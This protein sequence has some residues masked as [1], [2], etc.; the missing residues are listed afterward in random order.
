MIRWKNQATIQKV[1]PWI[2]RFVVGWAIGTLLVLL[3]GRLWIRFGSTWETTLGIFAA[4]PATA[5]FLRLQFLKTPQ[6]SDLG[7]SLGLWAVASWVF[8]QPWVSSGIDTFLSS[9]DVETVSHPFWGPFTLVAIAACSVFP[10]IA[11]TGLVLTGDRS[12][13]RGILAGVAFAGVISPMAIGFPGG[14]GLPVWGAAVVCMASGALLLRRPTHESHAPESSQEDQ[15]VIPTESALNWESVLLCFA[16]GGAISIGHFLGHQVIVPNLITEFS[17]FSGLLIG[18]LLPSIPKSGRWMTLAIWASLVV[19]GY[20]WFV[21]T[22]FQSTAYLSTPFILFLA[23]AGLIMGLSIPVGWV[24]SSAASDDESAVHGPSM[25]WFLC[26]AWLGSLFAFSNGL[27][28]SANLLLVL[29]TATILGLR[30]A[31]AF[32]AL[33]RR[34]SL[35]TAGA[36]FTLLLAIGAVFLNSRFNTAVAEK[37][38]FSGNSYLAARSGVPFE[39][40]AWLDD[41]RLVNEWE[42][43]QGRTSLWKHRGEQLVTR[44]NGIP[45]GLYSLEPERCPHSAAE[46]C[47]VWFPLVMHPAAED[48]LILGLHQTSMQTCEY[49]PLM[50]VTVVTNDAHD[51]QLQKTIESGIFSEDRYQFLS[52]NLLQAVRTQHTREYDVIVCPNSVIANTQGTALLT[53]ECFANARR[54]LADGGFYC[55]RLSYYDIG[56]E[57]VTSV[58]QTFRSVFPN[59]LVTETVPGELLLIGTQSD[60]PLVTEQVL[61]RVQSSHSRRVLAG[62]AWD[63]AIAATRGTLDANALDAM[64]SSKASSNDVDWPIASFDLPWEIARWNDK[65]NQSRQLLAKHGQLFSGRIDDPAIATEISQRLEDL[66]LAQKVVDTQPD[67]V[68]GYRAAIKQKLSDRPRSKFMQVAHGGLKNQLHPEDQKRKDYLVTLGRLTKET[69]LSTEDVDTL[70][71]HTHPFDPLVSPFARN[72][73]IQLLKRVSEEQTDTRRFDY[74]LHSIY[75]SSPRDRSVRN[76][77]DTISLVTDENGETLT[78]SEQWDHLNGLLDVLRMRWQ[79]RWQATDGSQEDYELVDTERCLDAI[80][81][82]M[83]TMEELRV[84]ANVRQ[85]DWENRR[86]FL[87]SSLVEPLQQYRSQQMQQVRYARPVAAPQPN[88]PS[89]SS[90]IEK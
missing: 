83:E 61:E 6:R 77:C 86:A 88:A 90:E 9:V 31:F 49:F 55:Q 11:G 41:G 74:L 70:I 22:A 36:A 58:L 75:F 32:G 13:N 54:H 80:D 76:V 57:T 34:V 35:Q 3:V 81:S 38:L 16:C 73:A 85:G 27:T 21:W 46:V 50:S 37:T 30:Q 4:L 52:A 67:N 25:L 84:E 40:L 33:Q 82:A 20:P 72:E 1:S 62:M 8:L 69:E 45:S 14:W 71:E 65:M 79:T 48:V 68:W 64:M 18:A 17:L 23:R 51:G 28:S 7:R 78:P 66:R 19:L 56:P 2:S 42:T 44:T 43:L 59:L 60:Q 53:E 15:N 26:A 24:L 29:A 63:W 89:T 47:P 12:S 10:A 39:Q 5:L 87:E